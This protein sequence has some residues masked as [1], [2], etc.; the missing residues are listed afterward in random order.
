MV[1]KEGTDITYETALQAH[2]QSYRTKRN[3]EERKKT[4]WYR[5][6]FPRDA[7]YRA[8]ENPYAKYNAGDVYNPAN[9][10]YSST[11]N[12]FRDHHQE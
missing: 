4:A 6:L 3:K 12:R 5:I 9:G 8:V 1:H 2:Y 7:D 11:T 10:F